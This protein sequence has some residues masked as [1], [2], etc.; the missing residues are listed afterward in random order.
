MRTKL[1]LLSLTAASIAACS[2][3]GSIG[4]PGTRIDNFGS[5]NG[6]KVEVTRE[7]GIAALAINHV[8]KHDDR[9]FVYT[10][11][12][13]C[14]TNCP[15]PLDSA[16]G[17]LPAAATDSLFNIVLAQDPFSLKDDYGS[18]RG[19]ADMMEI[20]VRITSGGNVKTIRGDEGTIP[21]P[22]RRIVQSVFEIV[23]AGR[24]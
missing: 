7:G 12:H 19:A 24:R 10:M 3:S 8:V 15:A 11:R 5:F 16:S 1:I 17:T 22:L 21:Q 20:T 6:A 4:D 14:G 18:Q 23:D 13:L 9:G 2:R